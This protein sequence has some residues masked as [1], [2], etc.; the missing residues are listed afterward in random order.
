[1]MKNPL[2]VAFLLLFI[3]S[4]TLITCRQVAYI[5]GKVTIVGRTFDSELKDSA[6]IYGLVCYAPDEKTVIPNANIW[7]DELNIKTLSNNSGFFSIKI[8]PGKYTIKCYRDNPNEEFA[9]I[10]K[11]FII[12]SNE[13][14]E[15]KFFRGSMAE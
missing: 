10:L 6:M 2:K 4:I 7:I 8:K 15:I 12:S 11:D 9:N 3:L 14:V 1:M 5:D 13:K